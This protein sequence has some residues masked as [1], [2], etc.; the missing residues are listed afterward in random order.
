MLW[1]LKERK[2]VILVRHGELS[3]YAC[4]RGGGARVR[5]P[6]AWACVQ[7][8]SAQVQYHATHG[9]SSEKVQVGK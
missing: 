1:L 7:T 9:K 3:E 8:A 6:S 4:C 2:C 5:V